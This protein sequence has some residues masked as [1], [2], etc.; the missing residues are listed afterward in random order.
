MPLDIQIERKPEKLRRTAVLWCLCICTMIDAAMDFF[1]Y[2]NFLIMP[3]LMKQ[4]MTLVQQMPAFSN[5]E[6]ASVMDA[7]MAI[8][9]WQLGILSFAEL[10]IFTGA[11]I[12]LW[13][14]HQNGFHLYT[15]GQIILCA[16]I[17]LL[18]GKPFATGVSGIIMTVLLILLFATQ[19]KYMRPDAIEED[20][21]SNK[22]ATT[23]LEPQDYD[24]D[25]SLE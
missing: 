2:L 24:N 18:L 6:I 7:Y 21:D 3:D 20:D 10:L 22:T 14:Q 23:D 1:G 19:L 4:S 16:T 25:N 15:I 17:Y 8:P 11:L 9:A 13:K 5:E 12:M